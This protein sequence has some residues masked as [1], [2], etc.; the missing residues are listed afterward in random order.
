M[1]KATDQAKH[2]VTVD[3]CAVNCARKI[4]EQ[5]GYT[6]DA[7]LTL[8]NDCGIAKKSSFD[9]TNE[10]LQTVVKAIMHTVKHLQS[11]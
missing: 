11:E 3:G 6:P 8:V 2:I 1:L 4:V 5:A 10:D 9:F 7:S